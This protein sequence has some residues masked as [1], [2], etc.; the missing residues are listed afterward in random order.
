[1]HRGRAL[2]TPSR[3]G[4]ASLRR[5]LGR[6][7]GRLLAGAWRTPGLRGAHPRWLLAGAALRRRSTLTGWRRTARRRG[8]LGLSALGRRR[9][10]CWLS[11]RLP[12]L[13][14]SRAVLVLSLVASHKCAC[15]WTHGWRPTWRSD[16]LE[17]A[18]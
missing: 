6:G 5:R 10:L 16:L 13:R 15:R 12:A 14:S 3:L 9:C 18:R 17:R 2:P 11:L 4:L 8:S 1:L 7:P